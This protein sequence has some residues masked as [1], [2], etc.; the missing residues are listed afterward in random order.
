MSL[1]HQGFR[2]NAKKIFDSCK[3]LVAEISKITCYEIMGD[4]RGILFKI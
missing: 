4:P 2:D 1:G 3:Y